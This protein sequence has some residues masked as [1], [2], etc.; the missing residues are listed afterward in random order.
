ML[1]TRQCH[2]SRCSTR[3]YSPLTRPQIHLDISHQLV[4][5]GREA[6]RV[7]VI[8]MVL[9]HPVP[10]INVVVTTTVLF[11]IRGLSGKISHVHIPILTLSSAS[12]SA[13]TLL[14]RHQ[15]IPLTK[16]T[17][18]QIIAI[19]QTIRA[20]HMLAVLLEPLPVVLRRVDQ[21]PR[22]LAPIT[23]DLQPH[24]NLLDEGLA[25]LLRGQL[26]RIFTLLLPRKQL[27]VRPVVAQDAQLQV[28]LKK[29]KLGLHA[30]VVVVT[31]TPHAASGTVG[32]FGV[33]VAD[34]GAHVSVDDA[35]GALVLPAF[36]GRELE[37]AHRLLVGRQLEDLLGAPQT[38]RVVQQ[39]QPVP[40]LGFP[41]L[42]RD[43]DV[44]AELGQAAELVVPE[45]REQGADVLEFVLDR[46]SCETPAR[47]GLEVGAGLVEGRGRATDD[48]G[49][50]E[51]DAEPIDL[52]QDRLAG[53]VFDGEGVVCCDYDVEAL[54]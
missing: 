26:P 7:E 35:L 3:I 14:H 18:L 25:R 17:M 34:L 12:E 9:I 36:V 33:V 49:F 53:F 13:I 31:Q 44:L 46:C 24:P 29:P 4:H 5:L 27:L 20:K 11:G 30:A 6:N 23:P 52:V 2:E 32:G 43:A 21:R 8:L 39:D 54:C 50:V 1:S 45:E 19:L 37:L 40:R 38:E 42:E 47:P 10:I 28:S 51:H 22:L 15:P 16:R 41:L 48:V